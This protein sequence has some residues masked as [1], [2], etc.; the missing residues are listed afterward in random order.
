[1][2]CSSQYQSDSALT[3]TYWSSGDV[4]GGYSRL[5]PYHFLTFPQ[6][7]PFSFPLS[8]ILNSQAGYHCIL[9]PR[10]PLSVPLPRSPLLVLATSG[11][12]M[13]K[14]VNQGN[15][16]SLF[17]VYTYSRSSP[18]YLIFAPQSSCEDENDE[19][20]IILT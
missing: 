7:V 1:M 15:L 2:L 18:K 10:L 9:V 8:A 19:D 4:A 11:V 14:N 13:T 6:I 16:I 12:N 17:R 5:Q 20:L 3:R